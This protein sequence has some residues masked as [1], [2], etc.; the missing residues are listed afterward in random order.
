VKANL[1]FNFQYKSE[2]FIIHYITSFIL[3]SLRKS[4]GFLQLEGRSS[5]GAKGFS[6]SKHQTPPRQ[7]FALPSQFSPFFTLLK[8]SIYIQRD[9]LN[10]SNLF[11]EV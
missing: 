2:R 6:I 7:R 4:F 10:N 8:A 3:L 9:K 11:S 1:I 5:D